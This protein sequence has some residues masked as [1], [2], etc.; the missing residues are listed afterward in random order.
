MS[1]EH[2]H[3][4]LDQFLIEPIVQLDLF[5][6][7]ISL[8]NSSLTMIGVTFAIILML[9]FVRAGVEGV[10]SRMHI[11]CESIYS[12]I[13]KMV[14]E[15]LGQ[16]GKSFVPL[17]LCLFLFISFANLC[18]LIPYSFTVTSHIA[19]TIV[20]AMIV[21][22]TLIVI[23]FR[24]QGVGFLKLFAPSGMPAWLT[25][26]I[27]VI[28]IFT[29]FARPIS[30]SLRLAANMVAGHV[31]LKVLAGFVITMPIYFKFVPLPLIVIFIGFEVFVAI[32]QAYIFAILSCVYLSDGIKGH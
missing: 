17:I 2:K 29:F 8:T 6:F 11:F 13:S 23:G 1:A 7:D 15:N 14:E 18:G 20:P 26:L 22:C 3:S 28:E 27:V 30:L 24:H 5:G 12:F 16:E 21:F 32:L 9:S 10:P 31:L 25:P 4:P 19:T